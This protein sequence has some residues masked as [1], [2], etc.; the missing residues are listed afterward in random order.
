MG[1]RQKVWARKARKKLLSILGNECELCKTSKVSNPGELVFDVIFPCDY[2]KHHAF[3]TSQRMS[4]YHAQHRKGNLQILCTY[5]NA[6]KDT[7]DKHWI[8]FANNSN[9]F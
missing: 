9:P 4:F 1:Q 6:T 2:G 7:K 5:H 8:A 3:D